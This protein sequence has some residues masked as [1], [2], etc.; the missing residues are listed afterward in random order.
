MAEHGTYYIPKPSR[1]PLVASIGVTSTLV[2][3]A[4]WLHVD[5]YGPYLFFI[6]LC[7]IAFMLTGWF[8]QVIYENQK[9]LFDEQVDRSYRWGMCWFI[10]PRCVSSAL[11]L[12]HCFF[13][14]TGAFPSWAAK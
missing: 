5:W 3:A 11:F 14:A 4:S 6:G 1:W 9:G 10:F 7:I 8:G 13:R 12:V 2:G